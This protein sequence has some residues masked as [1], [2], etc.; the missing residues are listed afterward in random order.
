M[1]SNYVNVLW[2]R[3][4]A[5]SR[6]TIGIFD[7]SFAIFYEFLLKVNGSEIYLLFSMTYWQIKSP[8]I[9]FFFFVPRNYSL[10]TEHSSK[11]QMWHLSPH[12]GH[13][14]RINQHSTFKNNI[15]IFIGDVCLTALIIIKLSTMMT[16]SGRFV[17]P[18]F[19]LGIFITACIN[20]ST[21]FM[22]AS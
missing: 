4:Q 8:H 5:T 10:M 17:D 12:V 3:S 19:F 21:F 16:V 20:M 14:Y 6:F 13:N 11:C 22:N 15:V 7:H 18:K 1:S 9:S 2:T